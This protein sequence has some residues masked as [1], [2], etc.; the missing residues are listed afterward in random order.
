LIL[1]LF[2]TFIGKFFHSNGNR[3]E[4]ECK[5]NKAHGQGKKSD[6]LNDLLILTLFHTLIGEFFYNNGNRY[7]GEFIDDKMHGQ[8]KKS[9]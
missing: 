9:D 3:Y 6:L 7:E 5:D 2:N 4:G 8:S 1:T